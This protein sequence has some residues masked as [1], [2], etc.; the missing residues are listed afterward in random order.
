MD[1][2]H[3]SSKLS[4]KRKLKTNFN[5][6]TVVKKLKLESKQGNTSNLNR[7]DSRIET[8]LP[9]SRSTSILRSRCAK[10]RSESMHEF[11]DSYFSFRAKQMPEFPPPSVILPL[12]QPTSSLNISLESAKRAQ[13]RQNFDQH[14]KQKLLED[15]HRKEQEK[16]VREEE[17]RRNEEEFRKTCIFRARPIMKYSRITLMKSS[18]QLTV[19]K[20]PNLKT[21]VRAEN[22]G[23]KEDSI[24]M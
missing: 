8:G 10:C 15:D 3:L 1:N 20:E 11:S 2:K 4:L 18:K 21:R 19:P 9:R 24:K 13:V 17:E 23:F 5:A 7:S 6:G 14:I 12:S 16:L 22:R